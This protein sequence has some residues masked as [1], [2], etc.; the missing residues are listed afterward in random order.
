MKPL[1]LEETRL[2][3]EMKNN[4]LKVGKYKD[5]KAKDKFEMLCHLEDFEVQYWELQ[6]ENKE[7]KEESKK[8]KEVIDNIKKCFD[9]GHFEDGCDCLIIEKYIDSYL[10]RSNS[11]REDIILE[12]RQEISDLEDNWNDLKK[13]AKEIIS[14]DNEL[15]GTDLLDK[16]LELEKGGK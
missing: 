15:Y 8:Q 10:E 16:I 12:Q 1:T 4:C 7:L 13:Y 6:Q 11:H 9:D 2:K 5:E 3:E 14:T